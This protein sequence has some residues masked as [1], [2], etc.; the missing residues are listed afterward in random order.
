MQDLIKTIQTFLNY[1]D[2]K[3]EE[4]AQKNKSLKLDQTKQETVRK[5]G[6]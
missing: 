4:L 2:E 3:L 5:K 1:S 6:E